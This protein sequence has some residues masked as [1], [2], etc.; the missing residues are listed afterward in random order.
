MSDWISKINSAIKYSFYAI[1]LITPLVMWPTSFELFEFNKMW[2]VFAIAIFI[3]FAWGV[4][5]IIEGKF[6]VRR[7][8]LDIPIALFLASQV[9]STI[10][11]MEPHTSLWGYY[12]RFNGGLFSEVTYIFLYYAFATNL[13]SSDSERKPISYSLLSISLLSGA[14]VALWGLPSHYGYDPTCFLFRGTLDVKCWTEQFQPTIRIFSTLG[15]PNWMGTFLAALIPI[16]LGL[17]LT[18]VIRD[19]KKIKLAAGLLMLTFLFYIC[20]LF[21]GSQSSF[22]GLGTGLFIF[23]GFFVFKNLKHLKN[24]VS[25]E[26]PQR[27]LLIAFI[28]FLFTT[29]LVGSPI[30]SLNKYTTLSGLQKLSEP[31]VKQTQNAKT[32]STFE[33][34]TNIQ[35]GGSQ[36]SAIR[37]IV[38][39]GA[40]DLFRQ[41][42]LFGT[43]VETFAYAY[44]KVKPLEHN[45]TSEW[46]YLYNKAH[47]EY[48]NFLATTGVFGLGSYL[49]I[50]AFFL[51]RAVKTVLKDR[52]K[53]KLP[54][55][56]GII[57]G[58]VAILISN[59]FGFS[60]V[61]INI[62]FFL[63]PLFFFD[64]AS[65]KILSRTFSFPKKAVATQELG[66]RNLAFL[67]LLA[68]F[69]FYLEFHLLNF[70]FADKQYAYGYN[71][72]KAGEFAAAYEPLNNAVKLLP[73]EDL[74][75]D[76]L[77]INMATLAVLLQQNGRA[78]ESAEFAKNAKALSDEVIATHP[79][80]IVYYKTRARV[81]YALAQL[82]P[83][84]IDL[85]ISTVEEA[86]KLAPTDAK[87]VYNEALFYNQKGDTQKMLDLLDEA[88]VLKPNYLD[89]YYARALLLSQLA[90]E[91]PNKATEYNRQARSDLEYILKNIDPTHSSSKELLK[92]L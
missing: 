27:Y 84:Y 30:S 58:Y 20:L 75:K 59:F 23:F 49:L 45:L 9:I 72:G 1:F 38:W 55:L 28:I 37:L 76:E 33:G 6:E 17:G 13:I 56:L 31:A 24:L 21:T 74:Y 48:L 65:D 50:I 81:A 43:G 32:D 61:V 46:D 25:K 29:F 77:S 88:L 89:V 12:S 51:L 11:S 73:D 10:T 5:M 80:N 64:I 16:S 42:P 26:K 90:K 18:K 57:G 71:L 54:L 62:F 91:Q 19:T 44:Y 67:V 14:V 4:K 70:W 2:F 15:Q 92:S 34:N 63:F 78:T 53:E 60:V 8:P 85:A 79:K 41:Y 82:D 40:L 66:T 69:S 52:D 83:S 36:S 86:R 47:N 39:Q 68:L 87:L 22:V 7:T 35:L 3:F